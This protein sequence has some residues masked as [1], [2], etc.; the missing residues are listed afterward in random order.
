M[1]HRMT[2]LER[3]ESTLKGEI[4]DIVP[5]F[6]RDLTL[7][8]DVVPFTTSEVCGDG[9]D[10]E[11]ASRS[12]I[13]LQGMIGHDAVVG[14]IHYM[15]MELPALGGELNF[16]EW[17][18]PSVTGHPFENFE[19]IDSAQVPDVNRDEPLCSI[20]ESYDRVCS[21]IGGRVAVIPNVEGPMTKAGL[22]RGIDNLSLDLVTR[23][24]LVER[25]IDFSTEM[26]L[27]FIRGAAEKGAAPFVFLAS[28][29]DNPDLFGAEVFQRF[30]LRPLER[31]VKEAAKV[32]LKTIF[33]P[34]GVFQGDFAPLVD[35]A[36]ST[37]ISG[38][39]FAERNDLPAAKK[40]WGSRTCILGGVDAFTTLL[41]GPSSR[42]E[43]D[44]R[45]FMDSCA[46]GGRYVFMCSG[47]LHRGLPIEHLQ[48]MVNSCRKYGR[49]PLS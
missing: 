26:A 29:T 30:S 22:L 1:H 15:G 23:P 28:A 13:A 19:R 41:L 31:I 4:P 10:A 21:E 14:A 35:E 5:V 20:M 42:I 18:I 32:G 6:P 48:A 40:R 46:P 2:S 39:Q 43:E 49:Y 24:E 33:H 44:V 25:L 17:G 3:I 9:Y 36:M 45:R 11:K 27:D 16:P 34:H 38:F 37:G 12:V 7:S 8:L 47:S